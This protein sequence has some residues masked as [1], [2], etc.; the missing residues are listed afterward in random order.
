MTTKS[1]HVLAV[2]VIV[3]VSSV[4]LETLTRVVFPNRQFDTELLYSNGTLEAFNE[5]LGWVLNPG[6]IQRVRTIDNQ[7]VT[8]RTD[9]RGF[10][11]F[12]EGI[13]PWNHGQTDVL[14][15]GDSMTYGMSA[16]IAYPA[17]FSR[18]SHLQAINA[19]VPGYGTDQ[20]F[21]MTR[22]AV[23]TYGLRPTV[24]V[25]GF[26]WNDVQ[27]NVSARSIHTEDA[28]VIH[29][30]VLDLDTNEYRRAERSTNDV[31]A[32]YT[33]PDAGQAFLILAS[34]SRFLRAFGRVLKYNV[35]PSLR[36][37]PSFQFDAVAQ[38]YLGGNL[39]HFHAYSRAGG[40]IFVLL[41]IHGG[42]PAIEQQLTRYLQSYCDDHDILY[43]R[44]E[45]EGADYLP[46]DIHLSEQGARHV[47]EAL[48]EGLRMNA[49]IIATL[50]NAT[51]H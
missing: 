6:V 16:N 3:S 50:R 49:R 31:T 48:W 21:L 5:E 42:P 46:R 37:A 36:D 26:Y 8:Y 7:V 23:E 20:A 35:L 18:V 25:Y 13:D 11:T 47:A 15:V 17:E 39:D 22:K 9:S 1:K 40:T 34:Q 19:A 2:L 45:L 33:A 30:P 28:V 43:V 32:M 27:N 10:R 29:K 4:A 38:R 41:H 14:F 51:D 44:P 12:D 24:I